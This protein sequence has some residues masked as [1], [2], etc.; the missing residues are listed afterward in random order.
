MQRHPTSPRCTSSSLS[1]SS[2]SSGREVVSRSREGGRLG[3]E[4]ALRPRKWIERVKRRLPLCR[5]V[6]FKR[7]QAPRT[8]LKQQLY[9]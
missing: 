2:F 1:S 4:G 6:V 7:G 3:C 5:T 8:L 9:N